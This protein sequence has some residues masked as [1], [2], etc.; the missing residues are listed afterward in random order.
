MNKAE[1]KKIS[2]DIRYAAFRDARYRTEKTGKKHT[3]RGI[4]HNIMW[5]R[6]STAID[7]YGNDLYKYRCI[8]DYDRGKLYYFAI[9]DTFE[10][11]YNKMMSFSC[12]DWKEV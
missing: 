12:G 2:H 5:W 6:D 7:K 9:Y 4:L 1:Y 10:E 11:A 8:A 3:T